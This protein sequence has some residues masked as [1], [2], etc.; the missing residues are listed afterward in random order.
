MVENR[1]IYSWGADRVPQNIKLSLP[2]TNSIRPQ[3]GTILYRVNIVCFY[4]NNFSKHYFGDRVVPLYRPKVIRPRSRRQLASCDISAKRRG[5]LIIPGRLLLRHNCCGP[6]RGQPRFRCGNISV[7][8]E[9]NVI[10]VAFSL[11]GCLLLLGRNGSYT[12]KPPPVG[13]AS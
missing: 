10:G 1:A 9:K 12:S 13:F 6:H 3:P 11:G 7:E 5:Q 4:C 2:N 8:R